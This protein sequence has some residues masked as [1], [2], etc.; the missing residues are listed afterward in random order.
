MERSMRL[1]AIV[2]AHELRPGLFVSVRSLVDQSRALDE[3]IVA[4]NGALLGSIKYVQAA[5]SA[6][7]AVRVV[8]VRSGLPQALNDALQ[9]STADLV[10]R[11]DVDDVA[12]AGRVSAQTGYFLENPRTSVLGSYMLRID[13]DRQQ[14]KVLRY[15]LSG[16]ALSKALREA[17]GVAHPSVA[18]RR[19]DVLEVGGYREDML[20]AQDYELWL[21]MHE[22]GFVVANTPRLL[23]EYH[24]SKY[25]SS[26]KYPAM[27]TV[28][29]LNVFSHLG[30]TTRECESFDWCTRICRRHFNSFAFWVHPSYGWIRKLVPASELKAQSQLLG[31]SAVESRALKEYSAYVGT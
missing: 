16:V 26:A 8:P 17:V 31:M 5:M 1:G 2:P 27:R 4:V 23:T 20:V 11:L 21:R 24:T 6:Y 30:M 18:F 12:L 25:S 14:E 9:H 3:I 13:K 22:N 15:P 19:S 29:A 10:F 28:A 7:E